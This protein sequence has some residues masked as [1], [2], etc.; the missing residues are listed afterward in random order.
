M[1]ARNTVHPVKREI[2]KRTG[3][4]TCYMET[5]LQ[6]YLHATCFV[7]KKGPLPSSHIRLDYHGCISFA[8]SALLRRQKSHETS[9]SHFFCLTSPL[10]EE[11]EE[12]QNIFY[13][14]Q[15]RQK[16]KVEAC[17][18]A[19]AQY[20]THSLIYVFIPSNPTDSLESFPIPLLDV[21]LVWLF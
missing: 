19:L 16:G 8:Y 1:A 13:P 18:V 3:V 20:N 15:K 10:L 4:P 5:D 11:T 9:C 14:S 17:T 7:C 6:G 21:P 12:S 2:G